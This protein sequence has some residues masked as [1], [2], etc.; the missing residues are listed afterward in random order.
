MLVAIALPSGGCVTLGVC[1][2]IGRRYE[3]PVQVDHVARDAGRLVLFYRADQSPA[4]IYWSGARSEVTRWGHA[5]VADIPW[6]PCPP[7][8]RPDVRPD[9]KGSSIQLQLGSGHAP[10]LTASSLKPVAT[11]PLVGPLPSLA[12]STTRIAADHD[13]RDLSVHQLGRWPTRLL[14][15]SGQ[16][17]DPA[18]LKCALLDLPHLEERMWWTPAAQVMALP[19]TLVIDA[20]TLPLQAYLVWD[21]SRHDW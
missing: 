7:N 13:S 8:L 4:L 6:H 3:V 21:L 17:H 10:D 5:Q 12:E 2:N 11:F 20:I 9:L 1:S 14:L 18:D 19:A 16:S 15:V